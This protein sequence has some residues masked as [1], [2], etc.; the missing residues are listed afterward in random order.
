HPA[1][2]RAVAHVL[3]DRLDDTIDLA[4]ALG[5][6]LRRVRRLR[7]GDTVSVADGHGRWRLYAVAQA[8]SGALT[9][10]ACSDLRHEDRLVPR[11]TVA[12][13]LTKGERPEL[14]TQKLTEIGVDRIVVVAAERSVVRWDAAR[15]SAGLDRL[16]RV[17]REAAA[18]CRRAWLP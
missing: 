13:A 4:A 11:L 12:F 16:R 5:H 15:T 17:A 6:H 8:T 14:V 7:V 18:Q 1:D 3:S 2:E 9:L 10:G